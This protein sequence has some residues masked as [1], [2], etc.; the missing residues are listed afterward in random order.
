M[1]LSAFR[2]ITLALKHPIARESG[3]LR[4]GFGIETRAQAFSEHWRPHLDR[5]KRFVLRA[6]GPASGSDSL[7]ILG[8]GR[9]YDVPIEQLAELYKRIHLVDADPSCLRF[10]QFP[11]AKCEIRSTVLDLTGSLSPFIDLLRSQRFST[12]EEALHFPRT[13]DLVPEELNLP[14][15]C[16]VIS[17][18]ILSQ[19]ALPFRDLYEAKLRRQFGKA[20]VEHKE[21]EW[22]T[23][24]L[25]FGAQL[26]RGHFELL[27]EIRANQIVL[28]TDTEHAYYQSAHPYLQPPITPQ[29]E[30]FQWKAIDKS[31][32]PIEVSSALSDLDLRA[33]L[34]GESLLPAHHSQNSEF[35]PWHLVPPQS[36][37]PG[38][39]NRVE[40]FLLSRQP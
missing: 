27:K 20:V 10:H 6:L 5:S 14:K 37:E 32:E 15:G 16:D 3:L 26:V 1:A 35:W 36:G 31:I 24:F 2:Y 28:I 25:P 4:G 9:L 33:E 11:N 12:W 8:A 30:P 23:A 18:S 38:Q 22:L 21:A 19:L 34:S 39:V 29:A 7:L 13:V 40:G 17:M